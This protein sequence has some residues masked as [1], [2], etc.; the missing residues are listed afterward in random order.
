MSKSRI[1]SFVHYLGCGKSD[2]SA[3]TFRGMSDFFP[4]PMQSGKVLENINLGV[5]GYDTMSARA[6][7]TPGLSAGPENSPIKP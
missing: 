6:D 7:P 4:W 1:G 2:L 3:F 5:L